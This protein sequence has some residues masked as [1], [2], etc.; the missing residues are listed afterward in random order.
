MS[1][2]KSR[3]QSD[4]TELVHHEVRLALTSLELLQDVNQRS[5]ENRLWSY[6]RCIR[7]LCEAVVFLFK[8]LA[9]AFYFEL[10]DQSLII[11][12]VWLVN[13]RIPAGSYLDGSCLWNLRG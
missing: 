2:F 3:Y 5:F 7:H 4:R 12:V 6:F 11:C 13:Q 8:L 10:F 1:C 9:G